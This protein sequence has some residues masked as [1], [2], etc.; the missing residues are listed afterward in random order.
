MYNIFRKQ[1]Y[2]KHYNIIRASHGKLTSYSKGRFQLAFQF[3]GN[4]VLY[5]LS[6]RSEIRG[7]AYFSSWTVNLATQLSFTEAR[8]MYVQ[9]A[10]LTNWFNV[11]KKDSGSNETF[12]HVAR[13]DHDGVF[14]LSQKGGHHKWW[15]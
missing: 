8:Y 11:F 2:I 4:L 10:I 7:K 3:D 6:M 13:I 5:S 14:R 1:I 12:Y 15:K 9:N